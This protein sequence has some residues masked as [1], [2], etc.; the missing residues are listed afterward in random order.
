MKYS[1]IVFSGFRRLGLWIL[2]GLGDAVGDNPGR[3]PLAARLAAAM[4]RVLASRWI[5]VTL[6]LT[7]VALVIGIWAAAPGLS[8]EAGGRVTLTSA[9]GLDRIAAPRQPGASDSCEHAIAA[10]AGRAGLPEGLILAMGRVEAGWKGRIHPWTLGIEGRAERYEA[11]EDMIARLTELQAAEITNVDIGCLQINL[12]WHGLG[13]LDPSA[14]VEPMHNAAYASA[15][16]VALLRE[17]GGDIDRAVGLYHTRDPRRA[18][19]YRCR[20]ASE[21]ARAAGR[22]AYG[23]ADPR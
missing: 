16:L 10:A 12:R 13:R 20:V 22:P 14:L 6:A 1:F 21:L 8:A 5:S 11:R 3:R 23:C 7:M 9:E 2:D 4:M 15:Y 18:R 17:T 19:W